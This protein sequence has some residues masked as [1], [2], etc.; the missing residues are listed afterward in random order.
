MAF[1]LL[2]YSYWFL[3]GV[4]QKRWLKSMA[5]KKKNHL[6]F[7]LFSG[8]KEL[9]SQSEASLRID[10]AVFRVKYMLE[11]WKHSHMLAIISFPYFIHVL[12]SH[13][14]ETQTLSFI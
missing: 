13:T 6:S 3:A 11:K 9:Q 10:I 14:A 8:L 5:W 1:H 2:E 12:V 7:S 4:L